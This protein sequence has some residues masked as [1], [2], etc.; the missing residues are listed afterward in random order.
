[1]SELFPD[2]KKRVVKSSGRPIGAVDKKK[3]NVHPN[4]LKNL[5]PFEPGVSP[6]PG[7]LP[8]NHTPVARW[9]T[10]LGG[11]TTVE[12]RTYLRPGAKKYL[13]VNKLIAI[14]QLL[15]ASRD[16]AKGDDFDRVCDRQTGR[17]HQSTTIQAVDQRSA[18]QLLEEA[19]RQLLWRGKPKE[20]VDEE[21]AAEANGDGIVEAACQVDDGPDSQQQPLPSPKPGDNLN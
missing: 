3:R 6:N 21:T 10:S 19:R 4:S 12:L 16:D 7:G 14:R 2:N 20:L 18:T 9:M 15:R 13:P 1:M 11:H 17:P 5:R 8:K